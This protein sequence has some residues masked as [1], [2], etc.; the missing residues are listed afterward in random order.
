MGE[1]QGRVLAEGTAWAKQAG[2]GS[3]AGKVERRPCIART[4]CFVKMAPWMSQE[5]RGL[6]R[7]WAVSAP[8]VQGG[9]LCNVGNEPGTLGLGHL[10]RALSPQ[11]QGVAGV[12][13]LGGSLSGDKLRVPGLTPE[14]PWPEVSGCSS[15]CAR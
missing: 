12:G 4:G 11:P 13:G 3:R 2:T 6:C 7:H 14:W 9:G 15:P 8:W 10:S 1:G 5:R